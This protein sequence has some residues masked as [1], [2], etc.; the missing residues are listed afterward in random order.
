MD[1]KGR[2]AIVTGGASGLGEAT[3]R[4]LAERGA[5]VAV[6]DVN[7][8]HAQKVANEIG[9]LAFEIDVL[10]EEQ[11]V[12]ALERV[13]EKLSLPRI[14][15]NCAGVGP[16]ERIIG[17]EGPQ[18]LETFERVVKINLIGTFNMMRLFAAKLSA[19]RPDEDNAR[20]VIVNV[21]SIA[22]EDGQVGQAAYASSKGGVKSLTLPA[23]REFARYGIR[24]NAIAPGIFLTPLLQNLPIEA[25]QSLGDAIPYP[26][27]LGRPEEFA[28]LVCFLVSNQYING[29]FIRLD[30]AIRLQ[31]R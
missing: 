1:I 23:A 30:G 25:Q 7:F 17:R 12:L 19:I 3:A 16:A 5:Q 2:C 22:A 9:G 14:L 21:A 8:E 4:M 13:Q 15:I 10:N 18:A 24:V 26:S 29:E 31:P 28:D 6:F 11:V 20:G 27:R